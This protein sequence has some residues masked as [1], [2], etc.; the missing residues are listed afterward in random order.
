MSHKLRCFA[1]WTQC[2][3][4]KK[5]DNPQNGKRYGIKKRRA[6][7]ITHLSRVFTRVFSHGCLPRCKSEW[8]MTHGT[9]TSYIFPLINMLLQSVPRWTFHNGLLLR[10]VILN[11]SSCSQ[12]STRTFSSVQFGKNS[13]KI[14]LN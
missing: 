1:L 8:L 10:H 14:F 11:C 13:L 9:M 2:N 3:G 5:K 12:H 4:I 6:N 7:K